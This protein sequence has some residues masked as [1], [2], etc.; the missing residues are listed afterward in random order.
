ML[1]WFVAAPGAL[2]QGVEPASTTRPAT[3]EQSVVVE[4]E[5][6]GRYAVE[7][8]SSQGTA[9]R[10]V[11]RMAG[12]GSIA[13]I[14]G[15]ENGRVDGFLEAGQTKVVLFSAPDGSGQASLRIT[16][17]EE[18]GRERTRLVPGRQVRSTLR[19]LQQRSYWI[20]VTDPSEPIALEA[21]GRYLAD[22]RLWQDGTWL[23]AAEPACQ[24]LSDDRPTQPV[25]RCQLFATVPAGLYLATA[26]GGA[27]E[28]W[29]E[30]D[31][32]ADALTVMQG[33]V[34][35]PGAGRRTATI[36]DMGFDRYRIPAGA[37]VAHVSLPDN[38]PLRLHVATMS[39]RA[40]SPYRRP[41]QTAEITKET[42]TPQATVRFGAGRDAVV[43]V[44]GTVGQ[45]YTLQWFE[46]ITGPA[47][48][49]GTG[50]D[51]FVA[52][53]HT[54]PAGDEIDPTGVLWH[55]AREGG[56]SLDA[57][58]AIPLSK[59]ST[60]ER[61]FNASRAMGMFLDI[62][63]AGTYTV[64]LEG[65]EGD[66]AVDR[67][68]V[69]PVDDFTPSR[70]SRGQATVDLVEGLHIVRVIPKDPGIA[71]LR[72]AHS[73][74]RNWLRRA[75]GAGP[76]PAVLQP[77]VQWPSL[78]L[79][80]KTRYAFL[81]G[82]ASDYP[83]GLISRPLPVELPLGLPLV[84][85]AQSQVTVPVQPPRGP[86]HV[87]AADGAAVPYTLEGGQLT[88]RNGAD[89]PLAVTVREDPPDLGAP[90][91]QV[92]VE[93]L[94]AL[95]D[96]E[97]IRV[98]D[99]VHLELEA[100][101][102]Q[103]YLIE[104]EEDGLYRV[105][106]SGRL[107]TA[108][109][110]RTRLRTGFAEGSA[111]GVGRNFLVADY[112]RAGTYQV[113]VST[114]PP[115]A[116][117]LGVRLERAPIV[118]GGE[119]RLGVPA[120]VSLEPGEGVQYRFTLAESTKIRVTS[121]GLANQRFLCR[122]VDADGWPVIDPGSRCDRTITLPPGTYAILSR[123]VE[124]EHRRV[125]LIERADP[126]VVS[127]EGHGPH[128]LPLGQAVRHV[129]TE[130]LDDEAERDPDVWEM[131]LPAP[132]TVR[133]ALADEMAGELRQSGEII[134]RL[135]PGEAWE[136]PLEQGAYTVHVRGVRR[137]TDL[138]YTVGAFPSELVAGTRRSL[139]GPAS[140][141]LSVGTEGVVRLGSTG[142][143]DTRARLYTAD[144][145][146]VAQNDD[147][148]DD[149]N[150]QLTT[151][152][153]AGRYTLVVD[154]VQW[155]DSTVWMETPGERSL[156][157]LA[158]GAPRDVT[159]AEGAATMVLE[160]VRGRDVVVVEASSTE[161]VGVALEQELDGRWAGLGTAMGRAPVVVARIG[162][163]AA[164][165]RVR[166][167]SEDGRGGEVRITARAM[168]ARRTPGPGWSAVRASQGGGLFDVGGDRA[169]LY[170]CPVRGRTC[171]EPTSSVVGGSED[172]L[173]L[174]R[175]RGR[176]RARRVRLDAASARTVAVFQP[177]QRIDLA[178]TGPVAVVARSTVAPV[179][180]SVDDARIA[181]SPTGSLALAIGGADR[182]RV[183]DAGG[184][185]VSHDASVIAGRMTLGT[186]GSV[187]LGR[188]EVLVR[189]G[190]VTE[191][192]APVGPVDV[193]AS[194]EAGTVAAG[195][196]GLA[197]WADRE[198][199]EGWLPA[200][201]GPLWLANPGSTDALVVLDVVGAGSVPARLA[202]TE[203]VEWIATTAGQ[204]VIE[205]VATDDPLRIRG[206]A[207]GT[208]VRSD[209]TVVRG[210]DLEVGVGG[211]LRLDHGVGPVIA[212]IEPTEP[213]PPG[214]AAAELL[215]GGSVA[216][217]PAARVPLALRHPTPA[218][219]HLTVPCPAVVRIQSGDQVRLAVLDE[220]AP[221]DVWMPDGTAT[222]ELAALSGTALFG[223][224]SM[225]TSVP[226]RLSEG[227]GP[228]VLLPSGGS[229]WFQ[230][231]MP[232]DGSIGIG[233]QARADRVTAS[234]V[235]GAGEVV[236]A[237]VARTVRLDRGE[238]FLVLSQPAD[239]APVRAR[240][241]LVGL[242]PPSEGPPPE[243]VRE[244]VAP[245]RD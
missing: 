23:V 222:V 56:R 84:V 175:R 148:P 160:G 16:P 115:S 239:R 187:A 47:A 22:L 240:P 114:R 195:S 37:T 88:V 48:V 64:R 185:P 128:P 90:L 161:N 223:T 29:A 120:R 149:W 68:L 206:A 104:V 65:I 101:A 157:P 220:G 13:G 21:V 232:R 170:A 155:H 183:W 228:E 132:A 167:W 8:Q 165:V 11:D 40:D 134:G 184:Q 42:R 211:W 244:Y 50:R 143:T 119:L 79:A 58:H 238:W 28:P 166:T 20:E 107:A 63:A 152:L 146:L 202:A 130:P 78:R 4:V 141:P 75:L 163:G 108:G 174:V 59:K 10:L 186:E 26:Y 87:V 53:M 41:S 229:R 190:T 127:R 200:H 136:G 205:V 43:T 83:V 2:A 207:S 212:R 201:T 18:V 61:R 82:A 93:R 245:G 7:A 85:A 27:G 189:A 219:A 123:P 169:G 33:T 192:G 91:P 117:P 80:S 176:M 131:A 138:A 98:D 191:L 94:T 67:F 60:Y 97:E 49:E 140:I 210:T 106:S 237:G 105:R 142:G 72:I 109:A 231:T 102:Q 52:T 124:V 74:A 39:N 194:L 32:G 95:P 44:H 193:R 70:P 221:L 14:A 55:V 3:G 86:V 153:A 135:T 100:G 71:T 116:G 158:A 204:R 137:S 213:A 235:S 156:E 198:A 51:T 241:S 125:T 73:S 15:A 230:F 214:S 12:L 36:S 121:R 19:D 177:P 89:V 151:R 234:V 171:T 188:Q 168:S 147:R 69:A 225:T 112:L 45:P 172:G 197:L 17:F 81:L 92:P 182:A 203:P 196:A 208:L 54:A 46:E 24:T 216:L 209:G 57:T 129:W 233:V 178:G 62:Q 9:V 173:I 6:F 30:R 66:V 180:L 25:G 103:T 35:L 217:G 150:F 159:T 215:A 96:F 76:V 126:G 154:A 139:R 38:A 113:T 164:P 162:A 199:T 242:T 144:G 5:R 77:A 34:A 218:V 31:P 179:G 133:L 118:D 99:P 110:I 181:V 145:R 111:N 1:W 122:F 243:V 224:V 227:L 236:A 226:G